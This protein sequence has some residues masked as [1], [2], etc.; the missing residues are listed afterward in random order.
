[1][2]QIKGKQYDLVLNGVELSS[3]SIR[4]HQRDL[5]E[6]IM[7]IIGI[8]QEEREKRFGFLLQSLEYGAPP[9]GGIAPGLDRIVMMIAGRNT[10]R[11]VIAFPK[12]TSAQALFES[13]P[14]EVDESQLKEL[15]I[16]LDL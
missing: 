11:D 6:K 5:Q 1:L 16:K 15:H 10:I 14:S 12:T 9:H 4:V 7:E 3:G 2:L 13:A 8:S